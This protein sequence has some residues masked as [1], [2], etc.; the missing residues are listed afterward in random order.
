[1]PNKF[2]DWY[3]HHPFMEILGMVSWWVVAT[4]PDSYGRIMFQSNT[5]MEK[6]WGNTLEKRNP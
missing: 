6:P 5:R 2:G 3:I 4:L 1:M